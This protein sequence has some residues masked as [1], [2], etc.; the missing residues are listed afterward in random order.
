VEGA[1]E[2]DG[3][4][5]ALEALSAKKTLIQSFD[6]SSKAAAAMDMICGGVVAHWIVD[7]QL[8]ME[9]QVCVRTTLDDSRE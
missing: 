8:Q 7:C 6:L 2:A 9:G 1:W 5:L 3:I 4:R